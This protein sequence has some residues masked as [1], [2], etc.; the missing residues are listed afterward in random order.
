VL[1][2]SGILMPAARLDEGPWLLESARILGELGFSK[3]EA[4]K[5]KEQLRSLFGAALQRAERSWE[6]WY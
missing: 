4:V 1:L 5:D 2:H 3:I 6:F